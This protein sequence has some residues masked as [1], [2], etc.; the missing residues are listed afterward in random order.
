M[1][2]FCGTMLGGVLYLI[3]HPLLQ[4][5]MVGLAVAFAL[6]EFRKRLFRDRSGLVWLPFL[7]GLAFIILWP[8]REDIRGLGFIIWMFAGVFILKWQR[9]RTSAAGDAQVAVAQQPS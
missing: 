1:M 6:H 4:A 9:R 2:F 3:W 5:Y 7:A 8:V